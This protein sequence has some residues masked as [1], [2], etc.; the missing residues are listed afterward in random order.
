AAWGI[1]I[2]S[3]ARREMASKYP[4]M[5][6]KIWGYNPLTN[7]GGD[8]PLPPK[9]DLFNTEWAVL[10]MSTEEPT[11]EGSDNGRAIHLIDGNSGTFWHSQWS[12]AV[13]ALPHTITFDMNAPQIVK[14][15]YLVPRQ[16]SS[17]QRPTAIEVQV[18]TDNVNYRT[19]TDADLV[20]G[21]TFQMD[22]NA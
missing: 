4:A 6:K 19:L 20:T 12:A 11:G 15:F 16:N 10:S 18:S 3:L 13:G 7:E 9:Y 1:G 5:E 21:Y 8:D 17:G 2:S 14:G 22:N